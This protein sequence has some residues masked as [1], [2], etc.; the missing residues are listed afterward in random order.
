[1]R[2]KNLSDQMSQRSQVPWIALCMSKVKVLS[3]TKL[4]KFKKRPL[5]RGV[6]LWPLRHL[7]RQIFGKFSDFWKS[8]R[9]SDFWKIFRFLKHFQIFGR[10]S[11]FWKIFERFSDF[12]KIFRFFEDFQIC[13]GFSDFLNFFRFVED[14]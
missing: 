8:F 11:K 13:G 7:I 5:F 1:M 3:S 12:W 9:F 10:F 6:V 2:D 14:F 4:A